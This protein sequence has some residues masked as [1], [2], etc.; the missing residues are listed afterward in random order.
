MRITASLILFLVCTVSAGQLFG[1]P[2][3]PPE[4]RQQR[5]RQ[6]MQRF[7]VNGNGQLEPNERQALQRF[8]QQRNDNNNPNQRPQTQPNQRPQTQPNQRPQTQPNN[9]PQERPNTGQRPGNGQRRQGF[10]FQ[11]RQR[12][13]KLDKSRL[14]NRFDANRDGQLSPAERAAAIE[15]MSK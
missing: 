1:Q 11:P 15:A 6:L 4:Q 8:I 5:F 13:N 3:T 2:R 10:L 7:D 14:L 9:R 12:E